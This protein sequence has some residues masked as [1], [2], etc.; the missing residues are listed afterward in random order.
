M[1]RKDKTFSEKDL[2]RIYNYYLTSS[3]AEIVRKEICEEEVDELV[4]WPS[5]ICYPLFEV[6]DMVERVILIATTIWPMVSL[7]LSLLKKLEE[8][9]GMLEWVPVFGEILKKDVDALNEK[10]K[11]FDVS[12]IKK[13]NALQEYFKLIRNYFRWKCY[14]R[15]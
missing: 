10:V 1:P 5:I 7:A 8:L 2:L 9:S 15:F 6:L 14:K 13:L 3:E 4:N 11:E 12:T